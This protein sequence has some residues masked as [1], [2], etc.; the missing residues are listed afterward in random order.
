MIFRVLLMLI[1][2]AALFQLPG[3][4]LVRQWV[5][6]RYYNTSDVYLARF[7]RLY[8][9]HPAPSS[10]LKTNGLLELGR[11]ASVDFSGGLYTQTDV[12]FGE[13]VKVI[14]HEHPVDGLHKNVE[15]NPIKYY[16][17]QV[18][19]HVKVFAN[20][21]ILPH[22]GTI[23]DFAII[24]AGA[25]VTSPVPAFAIMVGNPARVLRFRQ[26]GTPNSAATMPHTPT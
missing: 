17:L 25:V 12:Y 16:S 6:Y 26:V 10:V 2:D 19:A 15:D 24:G 14:T 5:V 3:F 7:A 13:D 20:A 21:I 8:A 11:G 9:A 22:V 1:R 4:R 23:G 18:G